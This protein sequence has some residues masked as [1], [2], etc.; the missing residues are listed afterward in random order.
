MAPG[1]KSKFGAT[2]VELDLFRKQIYCF[3]ESTCDIV[4]LFSVSR[5]NSAPGELCTPRY[6]SA[7]YN[8]SAT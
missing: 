4:G 1:A 5:N 8:D 2:M 7:P 6:A 3:E